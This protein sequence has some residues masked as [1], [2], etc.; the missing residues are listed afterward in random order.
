M[1]NKISFLLFGFFLIYFI[2]AIFRCVKKKY[3][4]KKRILVS[5]AYKKK[6]DS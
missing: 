2:A 4:S 1:A 3:F 6:Y 5:A